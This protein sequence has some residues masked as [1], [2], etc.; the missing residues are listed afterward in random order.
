[1]YQSQDPAYAEGNGDPWVHEVALDPDERL[2][3]VSYYGLGFRVLEYGS[4]GL[5]EVGAFVDE[6]G[7]NFWGVEVHEIDGR[8]YALGSDRDFGLYIFDPEV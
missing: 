4:R 7:S 3:Y 2:A 6:G 8:Q 1:M 5:T